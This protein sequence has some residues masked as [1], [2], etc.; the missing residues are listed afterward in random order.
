M[1]GAVVDTDLTGGDLI[2]RLLGRTEA[3]PCCLPDAMRVGQRMASLFASWQ[4]GTAPDLEA[5]ATALLRRNG[6]PSDG[7]LAVTCLAAARA[8][9]AWGGQPY[10][11]ATHHGEVATNAMVLVA[12][13]ELQGQPVGS[14]AT[15]TLLAAS[16]AH[17][18]YYLPS[19][20]RERFAAELAS[21]QAL[22]TI[23][24][25]AG[26]DDADRHAMRAL[27]V[28]TEPGLRLR[29][30]GPLGTPVDPTV[31]RLLGTSAIDPALAELAGFL[32]D[33]DLL[34]SVGLTVRWYRV[35]QERLER[36]AGRP[37]RPGEAEAFFR[38]I[39]G[40]DFLSRPGRM[41]SG[42]LAA[43]RRAVVGAA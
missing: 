33:A 26:C 12:I 43:I 40:V 20:A 7:P 27:V 17:D 37:Y 28:A 8:V 5:L 35:Q 21:A 29:P 22:D 31:S 38:D 10:H 42:N 6:I 34:S 4:R 1:D 13:A 24:A 18:L 14:H 25:E 3:D 19:V 30:G 15:A 36:E 16:L 39:V 23:A 11:S 9:S 41:L 32:S 2:G